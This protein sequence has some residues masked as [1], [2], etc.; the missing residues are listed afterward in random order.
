LT[1]GYLI[2]SG[3]PLASQNSP[4]PFPKDATKIGRSMKP[5]PNATASATSKPTQPAAA[6]PDSNPPSDASPTSASS[7]PP[8]GPG[9]A[10][11]S[12]RYRY[13]EE[14]VRQYQRRDPGRNAAE[15]RLMS[16]GLELIPPNL[17]V[18]DIPC[19]YGRVSALLHQ[20]GYHPTAADLSE[21]M[22]KAAEHFLKE[23][24]VPCRVE[25]QDIEALT[26][27]DGEFDAVVCFR[28]FHHFPN[29]QIRDRAVRE[30]CRVASRFVLLSYFNPGSATFVKR[31][32][33]NV[34]IG[35]KIKKHYT[36][37]SEVSGYFQKY[38]FHLVKNLAQL[39]L[40]HSLHLAV[41]ARNP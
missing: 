1:G 26:Y 22:L 37:L 21:A 35:R 16:R 19:G 28:L 9:E 29:P 18:L 6:R 30:I 10:S 32:L 38:G 20:K 8:D 24:K 5:E 25:H 23:Q 17:R 33:E 4:L 14:K 15:L 31:K 27:E 34:L 13:T 3:P 11:Y 2:E 12:G 7:R 40:V 36:S 41:F 39:P